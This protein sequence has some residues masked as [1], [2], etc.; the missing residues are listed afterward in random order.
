MNENFDV[1]TPSIEDTTPEIT[2]EDTQSIERNN[3][4]IVTPDN[5]N[6]I[7]QDV[8]RD[9]DANLAQKSVSEKASEPFVSV[10]YNH[11]NRD[12]TKEEAINFIQKG[13]HTEALRAKLEYL[14]KSQGMDVNSLVEEIVTAPEIS[15]RRHLEELYGK[16]SPDVEIGMKIYREKQ[17]D[18]YKKIM[19]ES[20]NSIK[21]EEKTKSVISRLADEYMKLKA[22][23]P[24]APEY[25]DLP[26]SVIREA[27]EGKVDLYSA[28]LRYLYKEKIRIDA[29]KKTQDAATTASSGAMGQNSADNITSAERNFLSG[30]WGR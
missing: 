28:Y 26:N 12:F 24:N 11:K 6:F 10:Q 2:G 17:S 22:E 25:S 13:M 3:E 1:R 20:E 8:M 18:E 4:G 30:L 29:A 7:E 16:D 27:A 15:Y 9:T 14:A 19:Q 21:N 23:M 5:N